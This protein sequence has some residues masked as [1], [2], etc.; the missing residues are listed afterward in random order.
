MQDQPPPLSP[1]EVVS[2]SSAEYAQ[3]GS[4]QT[5]KVFGI[6]HLVF[7][8]LGAAGAIW[9]LWISFFGNPIIKLM[10]N[11]PQAQMQIALQ[12][13][14]QGVTIV[15][16]LIM[17]VVTFLIL[18]AGM[19]LL[20]NRRN[21]VTWSNRYAVASIIQKM[22]NIVL[23]LIYTVPLTKEM[24]AGAGAPPGLATGF[25]ETIAIASTIGGGLISCVYPALALI[26]LNRPVVKS[27]FANQPA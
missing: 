27:W 6:L 24:M 13:K 17:L 25:M 3:L 5:V 2:L 10:G 16:T 23:G 7:G 26:L 15:S 9:A 22:I 4:P 8:G 21:A 1:E 12:E 14:M 19:A 11:T 20:K 18:Y